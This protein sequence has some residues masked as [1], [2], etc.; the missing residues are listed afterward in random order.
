MGTNKNETTTVRPDV[1]NRLAVAAMSAQSALEFVWSFAVVWSF[2]TDDTPTNIRM[3]VGKVKDNWLWK[4]LSKDARENG[5]SALA[6]GGPVLPTT[7]HGIMA[8]LYVSYLGA[9]GYRPQGTVSW[10]R[11]G[12]YFEQLMTATGATAFVDA[13]AELD[14][15]RM[16]TLDTT[17]T[18]LERVNHGSAIMAKPHGGVTI[19]NDVKLADKWFSKD[20]VGK[21]IKANGDKCQL[22]VL[23][24]TV[25]QQGICNLSKRGKAVHVA[26]P[27]EYF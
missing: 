22:E 19:L 27:E 2:N 10:D 21:G 7:G 4:A 24:E 23:F 20:S 8:S 12:A 9:K 3:I 13:L 26:D 14:A 11:I 16:V 5:A 17:G 18:G 6:I 1:K 15:M 25:Q